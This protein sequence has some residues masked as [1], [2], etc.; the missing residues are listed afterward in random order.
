MQ[1]FIIN[2]IRRNNNQ[3]HGVLRNRAAF[4][5][6][7]LRNGRGSSNSIRTAFTALGTA[8]HT[9]QDSTAHYMINWNRWHHTNGDSLN[10]DWR[11]GRWTNRGF[12][13]TLGGN[14]RSV[15]AINLSISYLRHFINNPNRMPNLIFP[16]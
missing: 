14:P 15:R 9:I 5:H 8:L 12:S 4:A 13:H 7:T 2:G 11:N 16:R 3:I 10:W 6:F 1:K